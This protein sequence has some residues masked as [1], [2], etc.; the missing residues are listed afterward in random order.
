MG[1]LLQGS[2]LGCLCH[3]MPSK[4]SGPKKKQLKN[5]CLKMLMFAPRL[6]YQKTETNKKKSVS[7]MIVENCSCM[8]LQVLFFSN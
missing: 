3:A 1:N 6:A 8:K 4:K 5:C 2:C 7:F